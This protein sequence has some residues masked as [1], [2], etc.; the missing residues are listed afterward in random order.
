M[1][2]LLTLLEIHFLFKRIN[3]Y[4]LKIYGKE[5]D[6]ASVY[7]NVSVARSE[8]AFSV[9]IPINIHWEVFHHQRKIKYII[10]KT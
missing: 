2:S 10:Y 9:I 1:T 5:H 8:T 4:F 3:T 6:Q 7:P